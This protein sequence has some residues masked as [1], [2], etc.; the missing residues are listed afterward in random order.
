MSCETK[1]FTGD[2]NTSTVT[3]KENRYRA[4]KE[5]LASILVPDLVPE[6]EEQDQSTRKKNE[7]G[8]D[9]QRVFYNP[10]QQFNRD[11]T[12]LVIKTHGQEAVE[13]KKAYLSGR[14]KARKRK[15][16]IGEPQSEAELRPAKMAKLAKAAK[17]KVK[18][19]KSD[20]PS[21]LVDTAEGDADKNH[22]QDQQ[23]DQGGPG[24][25]TGNP[26][27][28]KKAPPP[29][30]PQPKYTILDALSASG[31]RALRYARELPFVTSVTAND[32]SASSV[33]SIKL[34]VEYNGLG[35]IIHPNRADAR[36]H[37]YQVVADDLDQATKTG[38]SLI[39]TR[40]YDVIDLDP[41]GSA[42]PFLDAAI[43]AVRD[44]GGLLC[45]TCTDSPIFAGTGYPEKTY[46]VYGGVPAKGV[47]SHEVGLR[48]VLHAVATAAARYGL[49]VKPL[50]SL[51]VDYYLRLYMTIHKSPAAVKFLSAKTMLLY[52][53]D[54]GCGAW[55]T[56][57]LAKNKVAPNKNSTGSFY[58]HGFALAPSADPECTHCGSKTH[59]SG[60]MY[61]GPLHDN[62]F[63]SRVLADLPNL[64]KETYATAARIQG[65][66]KTALEE[67][68]PPPPPPEE[69]KQ[70]SL[71]PGHDSA[72]IEPYP[73]YFVPAALARTLRC[74]TPREDVI[75]GGLLS[76]G[77]RITR[78]HC[79][80][81]S[82]KTDASWDVIWHVMRE[83]VRQ[84]APVKAESIKEGSVA[85]RLLGLGKQ[86]QEQRQGEHE[87]DKE[88]DDESE[89]SK[90]KVADNKKE[91]G[92]HELSEVI[93]DEVRGRHT[94]KDSEGNKIVRYQMNPTK[95]WGPMNKASGT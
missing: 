17:V 87:K 94:R 37:M 65:V 16:G 41:Y 31:L 38:P 33:E 23:K 79:K 35:K 92:Q 47:F 77:Y 11:L 88:K 89:T 57:L 26:G 55:K 56:Q 18:A 13:R 14:K 40:K 28:T 50:L 74:Q 43:Q 64:S 7:D 90:G 75:R 53:C 27:E 63:I 44:D 70:I 71:P 42:S 36:G 61:A 85:W 78:S 80:P 10:I 46:A 1:A 76:M 82:L 62:G 52:N 2:K 93:F 51:S 69:A 6:S 5:G 32:L 73:F 12:V 86:Q 30:S 39:R 91:E 3:Y 34:N 72:A 45:V 83:F 58:K 8:S 49:A 15:E 9:V 60:P 81:G 4:I 25:A 48:L 19:E 24:E 54:Y 84:K 20:A 68:I 29:Q 59:L 21:E 22:T 95:N 67:H 66:L